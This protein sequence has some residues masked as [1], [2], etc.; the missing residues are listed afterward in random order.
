MY[1]VRLSSCGNPDFGQYAPL[2][3]PETV[4]RETLADMVKA[5]EE[6]RGFWDLGGG[7][8]MT[9]AIKKNGKV[10]GYISYNGRVWESRDLDAK[11]IVIG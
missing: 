7:N 5:A 9:P 4:T 8:W 1:T 10:V 3:E 11:E 2:S 6:Y